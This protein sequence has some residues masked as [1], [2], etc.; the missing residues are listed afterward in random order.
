MACNMAN[1]SKFYISAY[2]IF[3][4]IW[5]RLHIEISLYKYTFRKLTILSYATGMHNRLF[6]FT[7]EEDFWC[8]YKIKTYIVLYIQP[9]LF[10]ITIS[11]KSFWYIVQSVTNHVGKVQRLF[12]T[13]ELYES[14]ATW[15][16]HFRKSSFF[17]KRPKNGKF[18]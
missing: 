7:R 12:G 15:N 13:V 17:L 18:L 11:K 5:V 9:V 16:S 14:V 6:N 10:K 8:H 3:D 1:I 4:W 2:I